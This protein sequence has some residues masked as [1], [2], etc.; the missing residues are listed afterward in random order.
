MPLLARGVC[1]IHHD[2]MLLFGHSQNLG[3]C[4]MKKGKGEKTRIIHMQ[5]N[6]IGCKQ[7]GSN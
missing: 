7:P 3:K 6:G 2:M 4:Y 1:V 5:F